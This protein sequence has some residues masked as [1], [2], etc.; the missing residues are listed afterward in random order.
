[1]RTPSIPAMGLIL[2]FVALSFQ[3]SHADDKVRYVRD[4]ISIP[5]RETTSADSTI[6]HKGVVSDTPL[7]VLET[8]NNAGASKVRTEQ[9]HVGWI[10]TRYLS[11]DPG[12]RS[13]LDKAKAENEQLRELNSQLRGGAP[14]VAALQ[15]HSLKQLSDAQAANNKLTTELDTLKGNI[16]NTTKLVQDHKTLGEH[17]EQLQSEVT[18]LNHEVDSLRGGKQQEVFRDGVMAVISGAIL[19]LLAA[20]FWPRKRRSDWA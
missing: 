6:V 4:W 13:Q 19:T 15:D 9:G 10:P 20:R 18:R 16:S 1:M 2:G 11:S 8:D 14:A 17:A 7:T 12:A 3:T 5:L